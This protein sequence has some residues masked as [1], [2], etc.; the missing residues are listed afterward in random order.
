MR[1]KKFVCLIAALVLTLGCA[2]NVSAETVDGKSSVTY[3]G[4]NLINGGAD[5][6]QVLGTVQPGDTVSIA[7]DTVNAS[8]KDSH[9]YMQTEILKSLEDSNKAANGAYT[10]ALTYTEA[11]GTTTT[12]YSNEAVGGDASQGLKEVQI[13]EAGS[14]IFLGT[15]PAGKQGQVVLNISLD[16]N[17]QDNSYMNTLAEMKFSFATEDV[18]DV[19][20]EYVPGQVI[21]LKNPR[22][23]IITRFAPKTGDVVLPMIISIVGFG[24]GIILLVLALV[25]MNK[26]R[27]EEA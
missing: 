6:T 23:E 9:F 2:I 24:L 14:Y 25:S 8:E 4:K 20:D 27:Q 15:I 22:T 11:D 16:G 5:L 21:T 26:R 12:L 13:N 18:Y 7:V 17:T 10:V 3:D 19:R 1:A